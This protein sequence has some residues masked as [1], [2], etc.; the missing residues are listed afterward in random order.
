MMPHSTP[1]KRIVAAMSGGVDSSVTAALLKRG[2][3][4]TYVSVEPFHLFPCLDEQALRFNE[5]HVKD[6]D[7]F[8]KALGQVAG[9]RVTYSKLTGKEQTAGA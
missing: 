7:R 2:L 9:K 1:P 4:G 5:R 8:T 3:R 6:A